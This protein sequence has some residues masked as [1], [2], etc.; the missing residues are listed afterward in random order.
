MVIFNMSRLIR[1][2]SDFGYLNC[3]MNPKRSSLRF[4]RGKK[5]NSEEKVRFEA[6]YLGQLIADT[7]Y[8]FASYP[9][10]MIS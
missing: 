4:I 7:M 6:Y 10:V 3:L 2:C 8:K 5:L 9:V 1:L